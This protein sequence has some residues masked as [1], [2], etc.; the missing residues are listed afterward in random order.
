MISLQSPN[1]TWTSNPLKLRLMRQS[2]DLQHAGSVAGIRGG[3]WV[4]SLL[5]VLRGTEVRGDGSAEGIWRNFGGENAYCRI[6]DHPAERVHFVGGKMY[7][8]VPHFYTVSEAN[9]KVQVSLDR[10]MWTPSDTVDSLVSTYLTQESN[11]KTLELEEVTPRSGVAGMEVILRGR[12]PDH[13]MGDGT[14]AALQLVSDASIFNTLKDF[15]TIA[16]CA[17]G[18]QIVPARVMNSTA[19]ICRVPPVRTNAY[20]KVLVGVVLSQSDTNVFYGRDNTVTFAYFPRVTTLGVSPMFATRGGGNVTVTLSNRFARDA[21][22]VRCHFGSD[23]FM[24]TEAEVYG[25]RATC[26]V[27]TPVFGDT[28]NSQGLSQSVLFSLSLTPLADPEQEP[29][30]VFPEHKFTYV[31]ELRVRRLQYFL[32]SLDVESSQ[33][34]R[35]HK[36]RHS[37]TVVVLLDGEKSG[38]H[39]GFDVV[40]RFGEITRDAL[41][42]ANTWAQNHG[43][44]AVACE[45]PLGSFDAMV[46]HVRNQAPPYLTPIANF[47][48]SAN[49]PPKLLG[50]S[51][52]QGPSLGG[53]RVYLFGEMLHANSGR[54]LCRFG[55][56]GASPVVCLDR[57]AM[58]SGNPFNLDVQRSVLDSSSTSTGTS[59]SSSS[60]TFGEDDSTTFDALEA[61]T[62]NLLFPDAIRSSPKDVVTRVD[63]PELADG[64]VDPLTKPPLCW[65]HAPMAPAVEMDVRVDVG[66]NDDIFVTDSFPFRFTLP[67]PR[68]TSIDPP[69]GRSGTVV[70]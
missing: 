55:L 37:R 34:Q 6:G 1:A 51:P 12:W 57:N 49:S 2:L 24:I 10:R 25:A 22:N 11:A 60:S 45:V 18:D 63:L 35:L 32:K 58:V 56:A 23:V 26:R 47:R 3:A 41:W 39:P 17:F 69:Y 61:E 38:G 64:S 4:T 13:S 29:L 5:P 36:L 15:P 8:A 20:L 68:I 48:F 52:S 66:F 7:C 59:S 9:M 40:C 46:V 31:P 67:L 19:V 16:G 30:R 14:A 44:W 27:P 53:T 33:H 28:T 65:C 70:S 50:I 43:Y 21:Y 42:T 62:D 54:L